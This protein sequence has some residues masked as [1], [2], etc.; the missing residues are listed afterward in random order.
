MPDLTLYRKDGACSIAAHMLLKELGLAFQDVL[1]VEGENRFY[2]GAPGTDLSREAWLKIN[3]T[4]YVPALLVD[5]TI[6]TELSAVLFYI[7]SLAPERGLIGSSALE[8]AQV[9]SWMSW[10]GTTLNE[11]G[12]AGARRPSR[13]VGLDAPELA[14]EVVKA[15]GKNTLLKGFASI[16]ARVVDGGFAVGGHLTVVDFVLHTFWRWASSDSYDMVLYPRWQTVVRRVET[17]PSVKMVLVKERVPL[18][19]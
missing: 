16:E 7:A 10:L 2:E 11:Y 12:F 6:I 4:G 19:F 14:V 5:N 9:L 13:M 15:E 1:L 17:L 18:L 8:T 3:P